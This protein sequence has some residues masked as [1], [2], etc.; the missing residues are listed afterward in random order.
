MS[1]EVCLGETKRGQA[2]DNPTRMTLGFPEPV[3]L[4]YRDVVDPDG[5][6]LRNLSG[7]AETGRSHNQ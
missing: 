5:L 3:R 7:V 4:D 2:V 6:L 1:V